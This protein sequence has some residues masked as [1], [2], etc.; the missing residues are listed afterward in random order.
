M[1]NLAYE[2]KYN[3]EDYRVW[4]GDWELIY[5][6]AYAMA[7]SPMYGHQFVNGK[8]FRQLDEKLDNCLLCSAV[9]EMDVEISSDTVV[10][11]DSM[12]ICYEPTNKLT[13]TPEI[14]FEV[15]SKSSA[16]RDEILKFELYQNEGV[17]YYILVYPDSKKAKVYK[18]IDFRFEKIGDFYDEVY[19]FDTK[20]CKIDFDF[21]FIWRK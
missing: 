16:K 17:K 12:V 4:E 15:V 20:Y 1:D 18:L 10:R 6:D 13:K 9:I 3:I 5:G 2:E 14:V 21:N 19:S 11:P 7:P 8:I